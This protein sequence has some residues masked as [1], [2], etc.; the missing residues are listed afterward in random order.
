MDAKLYGYWYI[1]SENI[2]QFALFSDCDPVIFDEAAKE[3][4]W[5]KAMIVEIIAIEKNETW[6]LIYLPKGEKY[7]WSERNL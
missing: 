4:K 7:H 5:L 1:N 3:E 2:S 6:E